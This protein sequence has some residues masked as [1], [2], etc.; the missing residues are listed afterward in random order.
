MGK[1]N[2]QILILN[3]RDIKHPLAGGA[4]ISLFEHAKKWVNSG[5]KVT[6]FSSCFERSKPQETIK[7]VRI[8]RRGSQFTVHL[9][10][11]IYYMEGKLGSPDVVIDSFHFIPFFTPLYFRKPIIIGLI[12]EIAGR[13]W[14]SNIF[15]PLGLI[16]YAVEQLS[17]LFYKHRY[18]I[19]AS[20]STKQALTEKGISRNK[21]F[22][23]PHGVSILNTRNK[24]KKEKG[25]TIIFLSRV[26]ADKGIDDAILAFKYVSDIIPQVEMWI[27]GKEEKRGYLT[28][29]VS[30]I[31]NNKKNIKYFGFVNQ[32]KKFELLK[33][34]WIL[35]HPSKKE[36]WGLN[37]I[38]AGSQHTPTV[39]YDVE[40][41]R[42][43][44]ISNK[45]GMLSRPNPQD[46]SKKI[47]D[48]L[49]DTKKRM[50]MGKEAYSWSQKFSWEESTTKSLDALKRFL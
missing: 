47:I 50:T 37:V 30:K 10:A 49:Q 45:T 27:V 41:L 28:N 1:V 36:G 46:L 44:I 2:S 48:L 3:W 15:W 23:V 39:G 24:I 4:E 33:R 25:P 31:L 16:G 18:F 19:T 5:T 13:L 11:F 26:S 29:L 35:V 20:N 12:N 6:W 17:F 42:D 21:I 43:S 38:E 14:F 32:K 22:L 7:G 40:G 34:A 9:T 8:V